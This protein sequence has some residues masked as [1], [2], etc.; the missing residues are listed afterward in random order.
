MK[1][2]KCVVSFSV[3]LASIHAKAYFTPGVHKEPAWYGEVRIRAREKI[4]AT[5]LPLMDGHC[6][7]YGSYYYQTKSCKSH[8]HAIRQAKALAR[9]MGL[10][11]APRYLARASALIAAAKEN[12]P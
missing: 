2:P 9:S 11:I 3:S 4:T 1:K 5:K 7:D 6:G 12:K 8:T 10:E